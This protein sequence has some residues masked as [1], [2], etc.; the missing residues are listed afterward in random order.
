MKKWEDIVKD[1]ME[2]QG[3]ALPEDVYNE[4]RTRLDGTEPAPARRR[5]PLALVLVPAAA[6]CLA[7]VLL[8][9][10]PSVPDDGITVVTQPATQVAPTA[11][12]SFETETKADSEPIQTGNPTR[13][14]VARKDDGEPMKEPENG[15]IVE[16]STPST[17][18]YHSSST[19]SVAPKEGNDIVSNPESY[20]TIIPAAMDS[21]SVKMKIGPVGGSVLGVG[22]L[23]TLGSLAASLSKTT[24]DG[25]VSPVQQNDPVYGNPSAISGTYKHHFPIIVGLS[26]RYPVSDRLHFTTGVDYSLYRTTLSYGGTAELKQSV[27]Y[28]GIPVRLDWTIASVKWLEFYVGGGLKGDLCLS[29]DLDSKRINKDGASISLTGTSGIQFNLTRDIGI[30][31]EPDLS[32]QFLARETAIQTYRSQHPL[33]FSV[34]TGL[35]INLKN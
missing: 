14:Y 28:L 34:S 5:F 18:T 6:T 8:L 4:F 17:E 9:H 3:S 10:R 19:D 20:E 25:S 27:H 16:Q 30:Y 32:W 21:K 12:V 13:R 24:M 15:T 31:L 29:A 26:A 33:M 2:E 7:T 23:G 11:S 35:R 1:K 22:V